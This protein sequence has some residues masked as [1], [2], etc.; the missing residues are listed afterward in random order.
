MGIFTWIF[1]HEWIF[2]YINYILYNNIDLIFLDDLLNLYDRIYKTF[3]NLNY[4]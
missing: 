4:K 1:L 3:Y 2:T